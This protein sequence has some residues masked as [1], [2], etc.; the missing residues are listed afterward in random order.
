MDTDPADI[1]LIERHLSGQLTQAEAED[2]ETRLAEDHEFARKLRLRKTFPSLFKAAGQD[3]IIM[4]VKDTTDDIIKKK[5]VHILKPRHFVLG[6]ILLFT[7][8][9]IYFQFIKTSGPVLKT[10]DQDPV[11][12]LVKIEDNQ[13]QLQA[14]MQ[15]QAEAPVKATELQPVP[16]TAAPAVQKAQTPV[17]EAVA[18]PET[19]LPQK[20]TAPRPAVNL[21]NSNILESPDDNAS[22][23][24]GEEIV[25]R[26][27]Q[28]TDSFT[29]FFIISE[30][31]NKLA[32]WR[33][34]KPGIREL[35]VSARNFKPGRFYWYVGNK[36]LRRTMII[37]P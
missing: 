26:W 37:N 33:G 1:D 36:E 15:L 28:S 5:K 21:H 32:W 7:G 12:R 29:N 3:E 6:I 16:L 27:K 9:L 14:H 22:I 35:S 23:Y 17:I 20:T 34:I 8:V 13:A 25:F 19:E 24:R 2:F 11:A 18:A 30:A 31:N 10:E 4:A